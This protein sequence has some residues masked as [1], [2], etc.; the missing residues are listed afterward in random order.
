M[1]RDKNFR[2][3]Q[4]QKKSYKKFIAE[5][6]KTKVPNMPKGKKAGK[7]RKLENVDFENLTEDELYDLEDELYGE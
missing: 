6:N 2:K 4:E 7:T 5:I 3:Q 1:S